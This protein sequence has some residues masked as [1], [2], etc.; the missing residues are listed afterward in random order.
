MKREIGDYIQDIL[1]AMNAAEEFVRNMNYEDFTADKKTTYA[2]VRAIEVIGEA[3]KNIPEE[4]R[5]KYPEI[6][7]REMSG[8]RDKVIHQYFGVNPKR[9]WETV[10]RDIPSIKPLFEKIF[11]DYCD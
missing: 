8:M 10:Q 5:K 11:K 9:V 1:D 6:P 4:I 2:V 7:W 3:V